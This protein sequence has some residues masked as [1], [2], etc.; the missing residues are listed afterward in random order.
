[1]CICAGICEGCAHSCHG[2]H[3]S[4]VVSF[5]KNHKPTRLA[6]DDTLPDHLYRN[7][8]SERIVCVPRNQRY[9]IQLIPYDVSMHCIIYNSLFAFS[10]SSANCKTR[11]LCQPPS[12]FQYINYCVYVI[13]FL[14]HVLLLPAHDLFITHSVLLFIGK[15]LISPIHPA[16]FL[17]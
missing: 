9:V 7:V 16:V 3:A 6:H 12:Q 17:D 15:H 14:F 10:L 8:I 1:M 13:H 11:C 5:I 2:E 4:S